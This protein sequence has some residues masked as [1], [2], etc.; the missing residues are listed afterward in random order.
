MPV[1]TRWWH[2]GR[3]TIDQ[4]Q[5]CEVQLVHPGTSLVTTWLAVLSPAGSPI[6]PELI[7]ACAHSTGSTGL[8]RLCTR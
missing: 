1:G 2:Q 8:F 4:L 3:N 7:A 6:T 5:R